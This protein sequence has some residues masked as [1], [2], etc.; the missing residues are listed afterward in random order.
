MTHTPS[1]AA[2]PHATTHDEA[3]TAGGIA[4][5]SGE[6]KSDDRAE[7]EPARTIGRLRSVLLGLSGGAFATAVMTLFRM[8]ITDSMPP[9]ADFLARYL[10]GGPEDYTVSAFV[11]HLVY[12]MG[13]GGLYGLL[14]SGRGGRTRSEIEIRD[15]AVALGYS[16]VFSLFGSRVVLKRL[17]GMDLTSDEALIFHVGHAIY[18]LALGAWVGSK[19]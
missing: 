7:A 8:P 4:T 19:R 1:E 15:M 3:S 14:V 12:G 17:V 16:L 2:G 10:G 18:G 13:G 6:S 11:L 5:H 9:T